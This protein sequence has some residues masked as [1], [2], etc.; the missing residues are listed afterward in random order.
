MLEVCLF[1]AFFYSSLFLSRK[2]K[3]LFE[4]NKDFK[5][6]LS[7]HFDPDSGS[8]WV[9]TYV[10]PPPRVVVRVVGAGF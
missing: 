2:R 4:D 7:R 8:P 3:R 9:C 1:I 10:V 6:S 5:I